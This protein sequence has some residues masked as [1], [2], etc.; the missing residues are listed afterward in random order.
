MGHSANMNQYININIRFTSQWEI[1]IFIVHLSLKIHLRLTEFARWACLLSWKIPIQSLQVV[2]TLISMWQETID[3]LLPWI[4]WIPSYHF[5]LWEQEPRMCMD[6]ASLT[7]C[8]FCSVDDPWRYL[9]WLWARL[10]V[11]SFVFLLLLLFLIIPTCL[12]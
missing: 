8:Q 5:L 11:F 12:K 10:F 7:I 6:L 9:P 4:I 2:P 1:F 3:V